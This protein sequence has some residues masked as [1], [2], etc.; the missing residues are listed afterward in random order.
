MLKA[1]AGDFSPTVS[2]VNIRILFFLPLVKNCYLS[3]VACVTTVGYIL[4]CTSGESA[5]KAEMQMPYMLI[6]ILCS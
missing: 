4:H 5:F 1:T 3:C 2:S 6:S